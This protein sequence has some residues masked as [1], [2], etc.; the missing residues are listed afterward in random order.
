MPEF[1]RA[2]FADAPAA[3]IRWTSLI[4][5]RRG[6]DPRRGASRWVY[7]AHARSHAKSRRRSRSTLVLL[8]VLI[9]MVHAGDRR[10]R[11]ARVQPRRRAVDR[12]VPH[13]GARHAGHG[14]RDLRGR[15]S[16]WR[17]A[18]AI[19]SVAGIGIVV[20]GA[21]A[22]LMRPRGRDG[23]GRRR[24]RSC[25]SCA[26]ASGTTSKRSSAR[27]STRTWP[28]ASCCRMSTGQ[29]GPGR[30]RVVSGPAAQGR[31]R[32]SAGEGAEPASRACRAWSCAPADAR[33]TLRRLVTRTGELR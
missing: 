25:C 13:R 28:I 10:Q 4:R 21:A 29:A 12:A 31:E 3:R 19:S 26:S 27:R 32:R 16:A 6:R 8:S 9:A 33:R 23:V 24:R 20:V 5:L 1:L 15:R 7:R 11:R 17:S 22:F 14:V 18:R 2:P 30:R